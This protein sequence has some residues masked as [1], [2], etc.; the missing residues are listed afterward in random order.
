MSI[1]T[2]RASSIQEALAQ[3]KAEMGSD[4]VIL[5][6]RKAA[7]DP[8]NP[9]AGG[10]EVTA[11]VDEA[12]KPSVRKDAPIRNLRLRT[13]AG[14][15]RP[16]IRAREN[17][18]SPKESLPE[19]PDVAAVLDAV[20][21][22]VP[23][24]GMPGGVGWQQVQHELVS[25]RDMLFLLQQGDG[26]PEFITHQPE[27]LGLYTRLVRTGL[28]EKRA[29]QL[30]EKAA[31]SAGAGKE[32]LSRRVFVEM[33]ALIEGMQP[34]EAVAG[35]RCVAAFAGPTGVGKTTTIAKLAADLSLKQKRRVGLISVDSYR[36][37]ALEQL[38]TYAGIMGLPCLPAFNRE[39]LQTA[40]RQMQNRDV[41]LI[42]TAGLSHLDYARMEELA[43]LLG[44]RQAI[45]THLVLSAATG[46]ENMQEAA[47]NFAR[48]SPRSYVFTK[49][50]E[51][52]KRGGLLDQLAE[53]PLP[54]SYVTDGQ[55]VPED[56][57]PATRKGLLQRI[58]E[59]TGSL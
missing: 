43:E 47:E 28:T 37:G 54:V 58:F 18:V 31:Q 53:Y 35:Q 4:A 26:I 38:K 52:R 36:I 1:K 11:T 21:A 49:L 14:T 30:M 57:H 8:R 55:R 51:T 27:S 15:A 12:V 20:K 46:R 29:K 40:L 19:E 22:S 33:M 23:S 25:I 39:D 3:V 59:T 34:F 45:S 48:L 13:A 10:F 44:G 5:S 16:G 41:I 42:D 9:Y 6:T 50:D 24:P 32:A 2:F 17:G 7:R 56:I